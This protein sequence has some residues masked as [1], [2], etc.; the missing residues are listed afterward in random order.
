MK[1]FANYSLYSISSLIVIPV[2]LVFVVF[3]Y[4]GFR[5]AIR[6]WNLMTPGSEEDEVET[7]EVQHDVLPV[8]I[9]GA[10]GAGKNI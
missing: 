7:V 8:A 2:D 1:S 4:F 3:Y 6:K 5:F 10:L 9:L